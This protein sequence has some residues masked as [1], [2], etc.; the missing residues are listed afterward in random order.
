MVDPL[1]RTSFQVGCYMYFLD[2]CG[3]HEQIVAGSCLARSILVR[4][5]GGRRYKV[6]TWVFDK[7]PD[8]D[9]HLRATAFFL[10]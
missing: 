4:G 7:Q 8:L 6:M 1:L 2:T 3:H 9:V 10:W 5:F